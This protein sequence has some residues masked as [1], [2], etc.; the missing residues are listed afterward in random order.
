MTVSSTSTV[1]R[2]ARAAFSSAC[3]SAAA[4][5]CCVRTDA[6]AVSSRRRDAAGWGSARAELHGSHDAAVQTRGKQH[7]CASLDV[8]R[9][10]TEKTGRFRHRIR[11]HE[12]DGS[13]PRDTIGQHFAEFAGRFA[14]R[15]R[16]QFGY[17][18]TA[19]HCGTRAKQTNCGSPPRT[20]PYLSGSQEPYHDLPM[21]L[22]PAFDPGGAP[23]RASAPR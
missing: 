6:R 22:R 1:R 5:P 16:I 17:L 14:H 4:T 23:A 7:M 2:R 19:R 15:R 11:R 13:A 12:V 8:V 3:I 21:S 18:D 9:H 20:A 10:G